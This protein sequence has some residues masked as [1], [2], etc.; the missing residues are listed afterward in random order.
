MRADAIGR[1]VAVVTPTSPPLSTPDRSAREARVHLEPPP[2]TLARTFWF[3]WVAAWSLLW[4]AILSPLLVLES[5]FRPTAETFVRWMRPWARLVLGGIGV[6]QHVVQRGEAPSGPVVYVSNHQS[7]LD[8]PATASAIPSP[9]LYVARSELRSWPFVGW[10]LERSACLFIDRD[11][12]R[13]ALESLRVAAGRVRSGESVLIFPEGGR[14]YRHGLDPFMRGSFV[15]AIEAGV[16]V[17]P[18]VLVGHI[19]VVDERV[20]AARPGTVVC[21]L[22]EPVPTDGMR[23]RDAGELCD[24]VRA[25]IEDEMRRFEAAPAAGPQRAPEYLAGRP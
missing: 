20:R 24:R 12:P 15:L 13:S 2:A 6:R 14:S 7:S 3:G 23:R 8:I 19:G 1:S 5:A 10:V 17:V 9:F 25:A 22:C 11:N 18:V 16:P 4:T 21:V